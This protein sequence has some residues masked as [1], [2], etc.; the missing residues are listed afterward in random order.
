MQIPPSAAAAYL[1]PKNFCV[2]R[3]ISQT[4]TWCCTCIVFSL[5]SSLDRHSGSGCSG[6]FCCLPWKMIVRGIR[7][8]ADSGRFKSKDPSGFF[9]LI[10]YRNGI[11][12][13]TLDEISSIDQKKF[14]VRWYQGMVGC[15]SPWSLLL[16][17]MMSPAALSDS[18]PATFSNRSNWSW[19]G[20][21]K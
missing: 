3:S 4:S 14:P 11:R 5:Y 9:T 7:G 21:N 20:C 17:E 12:H 13:S 2:L 8:M 6:R 18:G 19:E 10:T 1:N 15:A 16:P